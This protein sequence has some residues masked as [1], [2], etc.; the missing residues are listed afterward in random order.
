MFGVVLSRPTLNNCL[1]Y[2][3]RP[4]ELC[5]ENAKWTPR[6][7]SQI[8]KILKFIDINLY[9]TGRFMYE[10]FRRDVPGVLDNIF[11]C[12]NSV[13]NYFTRQSEYLHV[14]LEKS[15]LSQ[16]CIRYR[17]VTI[18]NAHDDVIKWKHFRC[19]WPF[20]KASD[21]ELWCFLWSASE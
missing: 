12:N 14:P 2:R 11:H 1:D 10:F 15:N 6:K 21:G 20:T 19:C 8:W 9:L 13:H 18:W 7:A 4:C 3:K 17:G 16:L 5:V